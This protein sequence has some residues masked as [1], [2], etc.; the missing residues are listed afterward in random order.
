MNRVPMLRWALAAVAIAGLASC[1][2]DDPPTG[3]TPAPRAYRMGFSAFPPRL[4]L[5]AVLQ[6]IGT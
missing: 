4:E 3:P 6:T 1:G 2:D 5:S